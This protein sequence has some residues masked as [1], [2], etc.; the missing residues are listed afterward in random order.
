MVCLEVCQTDK[1]YAVVRMVQKLYDFIM[2]SYSIYERNQM[3]QRYEIFYVVQISN[4]G[5]GLHCPK[6]KAD[7]RENKGES[8][9]EGKFS[10]IRGLLS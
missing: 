5:N 7:F 6:N 2:G 4:G 3:L 9:L 8:P 10:S 1:S